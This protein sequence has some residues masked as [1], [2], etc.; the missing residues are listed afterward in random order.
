[1]KLVKTAFLLSLF[2][3]YLAPVQASAQ[4]KDSLTWYTDVMKA[5][6]ISTATGKPIFALFTGSDWCI[7]CKRLQNNVFSKPEFI[8]WAKKNVVLLE[9]DF[10]RT[11]KLSPELT[12]QNQDLLQQFKVTGFPTVWMF[13]LNMDEKAKQITITPLGSFG[14]PQNPE[15]GKEQVKFLQDANNILQK[16]NKK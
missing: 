10:P 12:K 11:K 8:E 1:M 9:L 16:N 14:Y 3:C 4:A 2:F 6:E 7:W 5:N 13:F 15:P